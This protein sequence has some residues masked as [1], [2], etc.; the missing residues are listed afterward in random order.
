MPNEE[1]WLKS[2]IEDT[3]KSIERGD[4]KYHSEEEAEDMMGSFIAALEG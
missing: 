1:L 4:V 2:Q 3:F